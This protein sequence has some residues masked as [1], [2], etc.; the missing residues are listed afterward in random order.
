MFLGK[1][2]MVGRLSW[3]MQVALVTC[4]MPMLDAGRA[5]L[6]LP[7]NDESLG[8]SAGFFV[9]RENEYFLKS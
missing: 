5:D 4:C 8:L 6:V 2:K 1:D 7:V 9:I 3:E